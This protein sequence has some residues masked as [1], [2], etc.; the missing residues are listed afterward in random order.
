MSHSAPA[1]RPG[2]DFVTAC[3]SLAIS[4][5]IWIPDTTT[6]KWEN[7]LDE[8]PLS[9][10]RVCREGEAWPLAAGLLISGESP[11]ILIQSTG[12]FE[13]GDALR[14]IAHDLQL[15][16]YG[17]IGARNWTR[18][19][20]T[21]SAKRYIQPVLESWELDWIL[22]E[23]SDGFAPFVDHYLRCQALNRPGICLMA[24]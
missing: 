10:I 7:E 12:F 11:I 4:H 22:L 5:V 20:S 14:N 19:E 23:Q 15:P 6:G 8:S 17:V 16:V 18:T 3:T 1:T 21:D 13:S 9:L 24:E 2:F